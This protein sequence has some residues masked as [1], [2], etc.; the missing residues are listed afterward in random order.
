MKQKK[1]KYTDKFL[2]EMMI[3]RIKELRNNHRHSQEFIIENT[4]VDVSHIE[5]GRD[6]PSV[7]SISRLCKFYGIT[8]SEFFAPMNYPPKE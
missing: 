5:N 1:P 8:L 6:T 7:L 4:G 2:S 3:I